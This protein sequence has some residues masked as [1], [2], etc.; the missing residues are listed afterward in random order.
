[1]KVVVFLSAAV[2]AVAA[3][4]NQPP[5]GNGDANPAVPAPQQR[6]PVT[7]TNPT[8]PEKSIPPGGEL[9]DTTRARTQEDVIRDTLR[10]RRAD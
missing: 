8:T 10:D 7:A 4:Q 6:S 3:N 2:L 5:A 1:M 9:D